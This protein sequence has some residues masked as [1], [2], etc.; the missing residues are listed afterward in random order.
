MQ[1]SSYTEPFELHRAGLREAFCAWLMEQGPEE[2][3]D[4]GAGNGALLRALAAQGVP[5]RGLEPDPTRAAAA[6]EEGL[7]VQPSSG[8]HLASDDRSVDWITLRHVLHHI[9]VPERVM[10]EALRVARRG[11]MLAE[12]LSWT[13]LP[14]HN[15]TAR[16]EAFTRGLERQR[17]VHHADDLT[18]GEL[19]SWFPQGWQ[20]EVRV[21][22]PLHTLHEADVR[23][24]IARAAGAD[25]LSPADAEYAESF[26]A[27][28]RLGLLAAP[29]TVMVCARRDDS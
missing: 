22:A 3:L 14:A 20:V 11:I 19:T 10:L 26:V 5:G 9:I 6:R 1:T 29:G 2:V 18:A 13:E 7:D 27:S 8:E 12:P 21:H 16:L 24:M 25:P 17:G 4:I 28:A 15:L 23:A